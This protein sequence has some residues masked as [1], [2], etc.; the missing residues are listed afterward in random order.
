MVM[1]SPDLLFVDESKLVKK[2]VYRLFCVWG[3][4]VVGEIK[5]NGP[6]NTHVF[7]SMYLPQTYK[8]VVPTMYVTT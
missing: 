7:K 8:S 1:S 3:Y 2:I 4:I 5:I 6:I